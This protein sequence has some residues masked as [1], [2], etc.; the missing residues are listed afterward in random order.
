MS[1]LSVAN[2]HF[3]STGA[4][5]IDYIS[6][7]GL[8]RIVATGGL[9]LPA[10]NTAQRPTANLTGTI[11]YN[12][13]LGL[14]ENYDTIRASWKPMSGATGGTNNFVFFEN[15]QNVTANYTV[16]AGYSAGSFGPITIN[17][18]IEVTIPSTSTWTVV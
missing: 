2:V 10:G 17:N 8:L 7:N 14:F 11:R 16:S 15:Q 12:T 18:G 3:E 9:T 13:D 6:G 1:I 4:N 5:R